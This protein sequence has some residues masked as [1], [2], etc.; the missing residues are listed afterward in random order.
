MKC[1]FLVIKKMRWF[2]SCFYITLKSVEAGEARGELRALF[3]PFAQIRN[4]CVSNRWN[5]FHLFSFQ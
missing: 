2:A 5:T 3:I 1:L 4:P